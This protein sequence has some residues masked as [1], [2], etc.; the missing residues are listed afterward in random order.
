MPVIQF[1]K[2]LRLPDTHDAWFRTRVKEA[3]ETLYHFHAPETEAAANLWLRNFIKKYNDKPHRR[4]PHGRIE[5]WVT[6]LPNT[7]IFR[8]PASAKCVPGNAFVHSP[9]NRNA[10]G[11]LRMRV[12]RLTGRSTRLMAIWPGKRCCCGGACSITSYSWNGMTS[13]LAPTD[14]KAGLSRCIGIA[15]ASPLPVKQRAEAV[16]KPAEQ[17]SLPRTAPG[18][19]GDGCRS[20]RCGAVTQGSNSAI[21]TRGVKSPVKT[22]SVHGGRF[23]CLF[24]RPLAELSQENRAYV[25]NLVGRTLNKAE[26]EAAIKQRFRRG[27]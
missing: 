23:P 17:I 2:A 18:G 15:S 26:I 27:Q 20:R 11:S 12:C 16:A 19:F 5:D 3:H 4:E 13:A 10:G 8:T 6:N 24:D 21:R 9:V 25:G 14:L 1:V 22:S 7:P